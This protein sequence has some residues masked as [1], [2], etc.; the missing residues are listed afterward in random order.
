MGVTGFGAAHG[1]ALVRGLESSAILRGI[2][3]A[4]WNQHH[5][6]RILAIVKISGEINRDAGLIFANRPTQART[7]RPGGR[8]ARAWES[9]DSA[10]TG[11]ALL[12]WGG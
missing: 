7:P 1:L 9:A 10:R 3:F 11:R 2:Q 8:A 12:G 6:L 5:T 4:E